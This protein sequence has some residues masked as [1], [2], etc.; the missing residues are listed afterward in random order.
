MKKLLITFLL[1]AFLAPQ[2]AALT[3]R[4]LL[5][6]I[7]MPLAVAAV[8]DVTGVSQ[9]DLSTLVS[10]LNQANVAPLQF[11]QVMRYVPAALVT[12]TVR[13]PQQPL[14]VY[15]QDQTRQ[16]VTGDALVNALVGVLASRYGVQPQMD[17]VAYEPL[18]RT[19]PAQTTTVYVPQ[20][21]PVQTT[22][23]VQSA[24][25]SST[26]VVDNNYIP[27]AVR[28]RIEEVHTHPHGGPPGQLK[29]IEHVQT[30][31]EIVHAEHPGHGRGHGHNVEHERVVVQQPM[32]SSA[33]P[34]APQRVV[35]PPPQQPGWMPPGQAKK[36]EGN[37]GFV[38]PG[39]AKKEGEGEGHGHGKGH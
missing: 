34:P 3:T 26:F 38:P 25:A 35:V 16:G 2:A 10:S 31:A 19:Q 12:D 11:D 23:V 21:A 32:Y 20:P 28:T 39:Q 13:P 14:V 6:T 9:D 30:G 36:A 29:K 17:V 24:P 5:A 18:I 4:D 15:V 22:R 8:A 33:P 27:P 1:F 37:A 7:A